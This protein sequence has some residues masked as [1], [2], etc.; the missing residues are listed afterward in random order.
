[1]R[2]PL[3]HGVRL[4]ASGG[5]CLGL[6][7]ACGAPG[8]TGDTGGGGPWVPPGTLCDLDPEPGSGV[9]SLRVGPD[10]TLWVLGGDGVLL[11]Y[12]RVAGGGCHLAGEAVLGHAGKLDTVT[13]FEL[14]GQGRVWA[15]VF[16]DS[17]Q[18]LAPDGTPQIACSTE[19]GHA[20]APT[21]AGDRV[22]TWAV[23]ESALHPVDATDAGCTPS[24]APVALD[25]SIDTAGVV[26]DA[27]LAVA[28]F[29]T[30]GTLP[31]A[32]LIDPSTGTV[33]ADLGTGVDPTSGDPMAAVWD[34]CALDDGWRVL[35]VP[36]YDLWRLGTDG[37]IADRTRASDLVSGD[38]A[39]DLKALA[40]DADGP[41]YAATTLGLDWAVWAVG[42]D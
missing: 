15:L 34:L 11:R 39:I 21:P 17:L 41:A 28:S 26:G 40:C 32:W 22:Y 9:D 4:G 18:R 6:A 20:V 23:G 25:R 24:G 36:G 37:A 5:A 2:L 38:P 12:E 19:A 35:D 10:G 27:G 7:L 3:P 16:F 14:D 29:D 42:V 1:M 30:S 8:D 13:D 31:P 33:L